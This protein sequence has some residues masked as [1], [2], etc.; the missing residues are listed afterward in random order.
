VIHPAAELLTTADESNYDAFV[1][2]VDGTHVTHTLGYRAVL[3]D[4][5]NARDVYLVAKV[6]GEIVGALPLFIAEGPFGNVLNSLPFY[7]SHGGVVIVDGRDPEEV[8][9]ALLSGL[10]EL[11][12]EL[13]VT[14]AT[15]VTSPLMSHADFYDS[16]ASPW[17]VDERIGQICHLPS[18][19]DS[20]GIEEALADAFDPKRWWDVRKSRR[21]G[22][23]C[24]RSDDVED[25]RFLA[26][27]HRRN[28]NRLGVP[29]KDWR[30]F[31]AIMRHLPHD[32]GWR[33]FVSR[34]DGRRIGALLV[35]YHNQVAEYFVPAV[36][37]E[38][39]STQAGSLLVF[40]AMKQAVADGYGLWNLGGTAPTG[41]EGVYR[42][43]QRWGAED[44]P[45]RYF[46]F[47]FGSTGGLRRL[48]PQQLLAAYPNFFVLP[49]RLLDRPERNSEGVVA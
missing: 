42:F 2:T 21:L 25:M 45:Y 5:L 47:A 32:L 15:I 3:R 16:L 11:A 49:F 7:G 35:L 17:F 41:Q 30:V 39:R 14:T 9:L 31:E 26:D 20:R 46:G 6:G 13:D 37:E 40:E 1:G 48:R 18:A 19:S 29:P 10:R 44:K 22:V 38:H 8:F 12:E 36:L 34:L 4:A 33:L 43:K 23:R 28:M 27:V 24:E